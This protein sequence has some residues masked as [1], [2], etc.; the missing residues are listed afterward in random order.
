MSTPSTTKWVSPSETEVSFAFRR[1]VGPRFVHGG[2][3]LT[4][5]ASERFM[6]LSQVTWPDEQLDDVVAQEVRAVLADVGPEHEAM[7]VVLKAI[8][9]DEMNSSASGFTRAARAATLAALQ[10]E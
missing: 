5:Q 10:L 9:W 8:E 3:T 2:V 7:L 4:F 1:H 6:F